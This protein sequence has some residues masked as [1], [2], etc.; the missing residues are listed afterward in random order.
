VERLQITL[1]AAR[2]NA[3][4]TLVEAAKLFGINKDTLSKYEKDSSNVPRKFFIKIE[5]IYG[6]PVDNFFFGVESEFFRKSKTA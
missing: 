5:E 3:G 1:R 2:V 4:L 6:V